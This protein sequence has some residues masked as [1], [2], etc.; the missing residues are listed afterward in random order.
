V[1][2]F[3]TDG[4]RA[5]MA[6]EFT[7]SGVRKVAAAIACHVNA[8]GGAQRGIVVGY[9]TRFLSDRFADA[10][11]TVL[12]SKGIRVLRTVRDTPTPVV[13]YAVR[14]TGAFG[15]IMITASHNPPEYNGIKFIPEYAGPASPE[16]TAEIE[17]FLS[18]VEGAGVDCAC[19]G[20]KA[21]KEA[22]AAIGTPN[23]D[24]QPETF[25]P[26]GPYLKHMKTLIDTAAIARAGI[27]LFYDAMYATGRGYLEALLSNA[28]LTALHTNRDPL[29]GG[30]M[31]EPKEEF[32][33]ELIARV[34][35]AKGFGM[36]TDG[37]ADRFGI[38]DTNG[39]YIT[40]NQLITLLLY[41]LV[42]Y[43]GFK[44]AVA[45]TVATTHLIDRIAALYDLPVRETPVGFKYIGECMR[46][47][48]VIIGGEESGGLSI[49]G[50][51]PEKDGILACA[52]AAEMRAVVGKPLT[53]I[54][55]DLAQKVGPVYS[56]RID[57]HLDN[58]R[59]NALIE[60]IKTAPPANPAGLTVLDV[61]TIDG[62]KLI[63]SRNSWVLM[64]PSGTEP[65]VRIYIESETPELLENLIQTMKDFAAK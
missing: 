50:H 35:E 8:H 30:G 22:P 57:L 65:L 45:R 38:I 21:R 42:E 17:G 36:A 26:A 62:V 63:L 2:K 16:I 56:R 52:L 6:D 27:P 3:G 37:D 13:A 54:L 23:S 64:R 28:N 29:F 11:T 9:D 14:D 48:Q 33:S 47:E 32:L 24:L 41:Y 44:G 61:K 58:V 59:K 20:A 1:I 5:I 34:V 55:E 18:D 53:T 40:P 15:A 51:L 46:K 19:D 31:P 43:R 60:R 49:L 7:F 4:W 10:A 39:A 25:D 12:M